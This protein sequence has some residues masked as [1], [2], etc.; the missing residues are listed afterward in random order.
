M[1][2]FKKCLKKRERERERKEEGRWGRHGSRWRKWNKCQRPSD[3]QIRLGHQRNLERLWS[4]Q[5]CLHA[6]RF[7]KSTSAFNNARYQNSVVG[8]HKNK[9]SRSNKAKFFPYENQS[10]CCLRFVR[11]PPTPKHT[12]LSLL[13]SQVKSQLVMN[14]CVL[15]RSVV[16]NSL[17]PHG[18]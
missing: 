14:V 4:P 3:S 16:S 8:Q 1:V 12:P 13:E 10:I 11:S 18:L 7:L 2:H 6:V 5:A 9:I 17:W 15:S